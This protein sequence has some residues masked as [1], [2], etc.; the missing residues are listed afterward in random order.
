V[1]GYKLDVA[2]DSSFINYV[3][4]YQDLDVGNVISYNVAGLIPNTTYYY[5]VRA[6]N[7]CGTSLNSSTKNLRTLPCTPA[8][9]SVGS[10]TNVT[11]NS[12]SA[13][14]IAVSGAIDYRLDVSTS[15]AF[16][17]YVPGYQDLHVGNVTSYPVTGVNP[18][19]TYYYRVRSYNG[20][21]ASS[22]SS[23]KS[24]LTLPCTPA[25]PSAGNATKVTFN[26]FRANWSSVSGAID[27]RLDVSTSSTFTTYVPG[28]QDLHVG[29]VPG[30]D[31]TGLSPSTTYYYRV[32]AYNGCNTSANSS[33]RSAVTLACTPAAPSAQNASNVSTSS[34]SANWRSVSGA[35]DYR[36][37]VSTSSLFTTYVPGYQD[38]SVGNVIS[39]S[40]TGL[41]SHTTYYYRVRAYNG[42]NT[43]ANS[44]VKSVTTL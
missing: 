41:N 42:C 1:T 10:G 12:F 15:S 24:V 20:C 32:R 3:S 21:A 14:W 26:S 7:G 44:S 16:T 38:L 35:I 4:G 11:F 6:Y 29:H 33:S 31:V 23:S 40:V 19:T 30:Y 37:D 34:F 36:L 27:Y 5:R 39:F 22:N 28:Y 43:S 9:P 25:A 13:N 18:G 2:I 8:T 17:T